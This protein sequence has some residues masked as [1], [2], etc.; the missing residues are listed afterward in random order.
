[1]REKQRMGEERG[2]RLMDLEIYEI[3]ELARDYGC[4]P[5]DP[6]TTTVTT[7]LLLLPPTTSNGS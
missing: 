3:E 5:N 4:T 7:T 6:L 2:V 1:M